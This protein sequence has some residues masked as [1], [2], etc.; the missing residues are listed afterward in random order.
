M[1]TLKEKLSKSPLFKVGTQLKE[2][3]E[4]IK[5]SSMSQLLIK[6]KRERA[7]A[8][9]TRL[10]NLQEKVKKFDLPTVNLL[11]VD[12]NEALTK[13]FERVHA[14]TQNMRRSGQTLV[15]DFAKE[16]SPKYD[17]SLS[18][19]ANL[20]VQLFKQTAGDIKD[21]EELKTCENNF[22]SGE[23]LENK[24]SQATDA[25]DWMEG[26]L[27]RLL[28]VL[29][30][31][32][33]NVHRRH[34]QTQSFL[35][36]TK[37]EILHPLTLS[38]KVAIRFITG[39][40]A[41]LLIDPND[42][43]NI[44]KDLKEIEERRGHELEGITG[45]QIRH[46]IL[47]LYILYYYFKNKKFPTTLGPKIL[48]QDSEGETDE[49]TKKESFLKNEST[50]SKI[51]F[52]QGYLM[53]LC[54]GMLFPYV[55]ESQKGDQRV[56]D[57]IKNGHLPQDSNMVMGKDLEKLNWDV[58]HKATNRNVKF[59]NGVVLD[60]R[61]L[62]LG[63][64]KNSW[65]TFKLLLTSTEGLSKLCVPDMEMIER[66]VQNG[67]TDKLKEEL[68]PLSDLPL[69]FVFDKNTENAKV[70]VSTE[71]AGG[72]KKSKK[73]HSNKSL[74]VNSKKRQ[75]S[76]YQNNRKKTFKSLTNKKSTPKKRVPAKNK[77]TPLKKKC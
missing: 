58:D 18:K 44:E 61:N 41:D 57:Q 25:D 4:V 50:Q 19:K 3:D 10:K 38:V 12:S 8:F 51:H 29:Q 67:V 17:L 71:I 32:S 64:N 46:D 45:K 53:P 33:C 7:V 21:K 76:S 34:S 35:F 42:L 48:T 75:V 31:G 20:L 47:Y 23:N 14:I 66:E 27:T 24:L 40:L 73:R 72:L 37:K 43:S 70:C 65:E 11:N 26:I 1:N 60:F 49:Q 52:I 16:L 54:L 36:S 69:D 77:G 62:I 68:F 15:P 74:L 30:I 28:E 5:N 55:N 22:F 6:G 63:F 13:R 59:K 56:F 9:I 39:R 2:L